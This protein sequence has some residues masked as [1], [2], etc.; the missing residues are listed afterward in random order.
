MENSC[1]LLCDVIQDI[2]SWNDAS[3]SYLFQQ[4]D[5][6]RVLVVIQDLHLILSA[7]NM[8]VECF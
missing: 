8:T 7:V 2:L 4:Q 6:V 1:I 3:S 5:Y